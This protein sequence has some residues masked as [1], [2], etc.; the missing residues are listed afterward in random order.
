MAV[1]RQKSAM[2]ARA[3]V[4]ALARL[5]ACAHQCVPRI[6]IVGDL[7]TT[8]KIIIRQAKRAEPIVHPVRM[9]RRPVMRGAGQGQMLGGQTMG[10]RGTTFDQRQGLHHLA[11]GTRQNHLLRVAPA[12]HD[13]ALGIANAGMAHMLRLE[14]G[15]TPDLDH[16]NGLGHVHLRGGEKPPMGLPNSVGFRLNCSVLSV[17]ALPE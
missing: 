12:F 11:R 4:V 15:T 8:A 2:L 7:R 1:E 9:Y 5:R 14:D 16:G 10:L 17:N 3:I 6:R 13:V